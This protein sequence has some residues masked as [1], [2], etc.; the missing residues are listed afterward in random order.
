MKKS[1][2]FLSVFIGT[3]LSMPGAQAAKFV[4]FTCTNSP[5]GRFLINDPNEEAK[6]KSLGFKNGSSMSVRYQIHKFQRTSGPDRDG[7]AEGI[8]LYSIT[9]VKK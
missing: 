4:K 6:I 7:W 9:G 8:C 5:D 2:A 3:I 1:I